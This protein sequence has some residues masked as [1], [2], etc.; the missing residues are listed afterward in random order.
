MQKVVVIIPIYKEKPNTNEV[1]S[2]RQTMCVL[3]QYPIVLVCPERLNLD[4]YENLYVE[5]RG[6]ESLLHESFEEKY[7]YDIK[8][9]NR[10]L[11]SEVFYERFAQYE[12]M[13]I[14]QP[15]AYVFRDEL[16]EWCNKGYDFVGAPLFGTYWEGQSSLQKG[17]IGNGGLSLRKVESYLNFFRGKEHVVPVKEIAKRINFKRKPYTRWLVWILMIIGWRNAPKKVAQRYQ[18]NEDNFWSI[19]LDGTNYELTKPSVLESLEFAWERFPSKL[20]AQL[21]HLPFGCHAWEKYEYDT[22]WKK[23]IQ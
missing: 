14:C 6:A 13:L 8:G 1:I 4:V 19:Y 11:L 22:F 21:G 16:M 10:L 3:G 18:W 20:Y 15:D 7:F 12:Y 23:Y 17:K 5:L 9:Y 2:L